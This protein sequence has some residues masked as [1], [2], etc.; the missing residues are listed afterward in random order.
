MKRLYWENTY[1]MNHKAK[2]T[3][4]GQDEQGDYIRVDETIF[5]P[6]GGGQPSDYP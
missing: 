6:Q 5:H 4:I 2:I 1:L 3:A